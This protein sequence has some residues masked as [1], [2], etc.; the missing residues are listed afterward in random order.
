MLLRKPLNALGLDVVRIR[1]VDPP[2]AVQW[3][4]S[5][6]NRFRWLQRLD[7]KTVI[8]VGAHVGEFARTI[9]EILPAADIISFEPQEAAFAQLTANLAQI[10]GFQAVRCALGDATSIVTMRRSEFTPSSSLLPMTDR[11]KEAFPFTAGSSEEQVEVRRLDDVVAGMTLR[12]GVLLKIDVQGFE[13]QVIL[14]GMGVVSRARLAI[15]ETSF[16]P[17][18]DGQPLFAEIYELLTEHGLTYIGNWDQLK[19]P[20]DGSVLQADA[21]FVRAADVPL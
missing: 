8:D 12:D 20:A 13:R 15:V 21:M 7:L 18:Y 14:G 2:G 16:Q 17:L 19:S 1:P 5:A 9:H 11:H 3:E 6:E 4:P 10:P